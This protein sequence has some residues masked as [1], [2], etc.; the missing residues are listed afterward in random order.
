MIAVEV[1]IRAEDLSK[2]F[3]DLEALA[4]LDLDV[5]AGEVFG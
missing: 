1:A 5:R 4:D 3:G 2:R